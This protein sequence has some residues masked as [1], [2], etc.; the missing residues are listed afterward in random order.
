MENFNQVIIR[1]TTLRDGLQ[2]EEHYIPLKQRFQVMK[3][4]AES[5]IKYF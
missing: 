5:G 4:L 2:H 3:A 1:D